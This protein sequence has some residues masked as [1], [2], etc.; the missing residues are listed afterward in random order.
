MHLLID[1]IF[2]LFLGILASCAAT[3][4]ILPGQA[5]DVNDKLISKN[6]RYALGFFKTSSKSSQW[7]LG[8]WFNTVPKF[9]SA[10]I[11]N[12]D[13]P[14]K[15]T[16]S[17]VF[18]ISQDGNLV[19]LN[20]STQSIIWSTQAN[21]RRNNTTVV[22]LNSGNLI[23]AN[24]SNSSEVMWQSFDHP[25]G[26][27]FPGAKLGWDK[28]TGL[29]R[30]IVSWKNLI[31]PATGVY[32][33]SLDPSGVNQF[34]IAPLNSSIPYWSTGVWNGKYFASIPEMSSNNN[35]F[36]TTFVDNDQEKYITSNV[37]DENMVTRH[38]LDVSGQSK[39][40]IWLEGARDWTMIYA[41]PKAQCD[42]YAICGPFTICT[43]NVIPH[44][45]CMDGFTIT[46]PQDWE[47]EDRTGGCSRNTPLDCIT[48]KSATQT[49]DRFYS[50]PCVKLP[51]N[52]P[53]VEAAASPSEC[54]Q[55]CLST[56]S[57]TA[58]SFNNNRCCTWHNEL[59]NIRALQCTG[60]TNSTGETLYLRVSVKDFKRLKNN[61]RKIVVGVAIGTGIS[62]LGLFALILII[63][64]WRSK[65]KS[66]GR[67]LNHAEGCNRIIAFGYS[68]LRRATNKFNH[69][70]GGGS[71]GS[72]FK[73]LIDDSAAIAVKRLDGAYQGE[74]QFR[75]EVISVGAI[76]HINLVK[77]VGFCC[78]G[79]KRLLVYEY[80]S[81]RSLDVHLFGS[82][83]KML[84]WSARYKIALGVARGLAYLHES[85]RDCIIHCDIKPENILLDASLI[86]KVADFG[87]AKVLGRDFSRVLTTMRGTAGY[88]APEWITGV[89]VT[90]K[91][92]VY[93]YG[94]VLL[95]IISGMRNSSAS[96]SG[97]GKI[98]V[99]FPVHAAHK[100]LGGDVES[101][102]DH[103]LHGG[104]NL[105]EAELACKVACWCIQDHELERP[106]MGQVVQ[107]L[108]G[109]VEIRMPPIPRL[110]QAMAGSTHSTCS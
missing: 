32:C 88:L 78:E 105:D 86:P 76:Q 23:L 70:L 60:T 34:L 109:L 35:L 29:N 52:A 24:S 11:A 84:N 47:V 42:V 61:R 83:S 31:D 2:P 10:W 37:V 5:L 9:T 16:T 106:T 97:G 108:E 62:A 36:T 82:T 6:G 64:I 53:K 21:N 85:C 54:A 95:E 101:L 103:K 63:M 91:V 7:Y 51:R 30:R 67:I 102:L 13:K 22:L 107:I 26:T 38:V 3:D 12:R 81:N 99:Y 55:V 43:D 45:T 94:M 110:L 1:F 40:F 57:C 75:A 92:D 87:M 77:L 71:F 74:K 27:L 69:K 48:N 4:T 56:C 15:N 89:A 28:L 41:Q 96:C 14:I 17:M 8:I 49:T 33:Q 73:G 65:R 93:S 39:M 58:Y 19:I 68:D 72:V 44:C 79:S 50:V 20:Q 104:V 25:T 80:M 59:L 98:D 90:P 100:L 18:T 66:S 46:S